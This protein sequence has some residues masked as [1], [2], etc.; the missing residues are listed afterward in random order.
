MI[1]SLPPS[2]SQSEPVVWSQLR[3][4]QGFCKGKQTD[5]NCSCAFFNCS[6][7][8]CVTEDCGASWMI[9]SWKGASIALWKCEIFSKKTFKT[10]CRLSTWQSAQQRK[11]KNFLQL[12]NLYQHHGI[13]L[14]KIVSSIFLF[15]FWN[16]VSGIYFTGWEATHWLGEDRWWLKLPDHLQYI[17][18]KAIQAYLWPRR[19]TQQSRET[20]SL[21]LF[22]NFMAIVVSRVRSW[23][24]PQRG[25]R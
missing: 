1:F 11:I 14:L 16:I 15:V 12:S 2:H 8:C 25:Q 21:P 5:L 20:E 4:P 3:F 6:L 13:S 17:T 22:I 9:L 24:R 19:M 10:I 18:W 23:A 7:I